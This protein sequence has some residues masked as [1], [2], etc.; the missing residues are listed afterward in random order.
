MAT[1][2]ANPK[3]WAT[4]V[5]MARAKYSNYP[6]PGASNWVHKRYVQAG[7]QFIETTEASRRKK[8]AQK[9]HEAEQ[10]K[11][12]LIKKDNKKKKDKGKK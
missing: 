8:M 12:Q 4:I 1:K 10:Q 11:K 5:A 9:K 6:N 2:P 7:G 3:L